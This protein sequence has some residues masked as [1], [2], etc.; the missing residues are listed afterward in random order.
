MSLYR[1]ISVSF[2]TDSKIDD[3]F[4]PEDK[5]FYLY[6]LTNPHTNICGCYE[7]SY[8]QME[9]ETG[10]NE[11][12]VKRLLK[13]LEQ[14]HNVIRYDTKSKEVL[15]INWSKYNWARS[16][17]VEKAIFRVG[18]KIKSETFKNFIFALINNN[19][20]IIYNNIS[21]S[22]TDTDT[23]TDTAVSTATADMHTISIP[24]P[25]HID[26]VSI[27]YSYG[28]NTVSES[29][30]T[31]LYRIIEEYTE[32]ADLQQALKEFVKLR[33]ALKSPLTDR[34][35]TLSFNKLDK[36]ATD[37]ET[38]IAIIN[39]SIERGWKG[40]FPLKKEEQPENKET[41]DYSEYNVVINKFLE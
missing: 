38:K 34:A 3:E 18:E 32:N 2:W 40:L 7:I 19:N 37:D 30:K 12:T 28:I 14:T 6:L 35:L 21:V 33:K 29:Q 41:E 39:Q 8:K 4:T 10:Y 26:T 15:L 22:E 23:E 31:S 13:R 9:R 11:D 5:Y 27:P 36:L 16:E 25:N 1:N 17:K 20:K 24:Y